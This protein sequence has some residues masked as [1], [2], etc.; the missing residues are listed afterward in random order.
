MGGPTKENKRNMND[1][2]TGSFPEYLKRL[3]IDRKLSIR[4]LAKISGADSGGITRMESGETKTPQPD[5]LKALAAALEVPVADMFTMAGYANRDEL[6]SMG[7]Y[8]HARYGHL[9]EE[10]LAAVED[11]LQKLASEHALDLD[12]P[13]HLE[14]EE[15]EPAQP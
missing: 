4:G 13:G 15:A 3:R 12:G 7:T 2:N 11:Y 5:T 8:L 6:P 9:P 10:M 1:N 14:D